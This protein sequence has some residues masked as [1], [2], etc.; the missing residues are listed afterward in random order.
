MERARPRL[1]SWQ[2]VLVFGLLLS[3]I[4]G[5]GSFTFDFYAGS[6]TAGFGVMGDISGIG[7]YFTYILAYFIALVVVLPILL[8]RRFGVGTAVYLPYAVG[9]LFVEYYMEWVLTRSLVS[10]WAVAGWCA[11]GLATGFSADLAYQFLPSRLDDRWRAIATGVAVGLATFLSVAVA[12]S[13]F[14]VGEKAITPGTYLGVAY[15]GA[16]FM[17][18]SSAFGGY[19][20]YAI[21]RGV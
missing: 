14:Y 19:T 20:A 18:I 6:A 12:L 10:V 4:Y 1:K 3:A 13:F 7:M 17:L 9:G 16:P 2:I 11:L 15:Y 5:F 21:S 8:I